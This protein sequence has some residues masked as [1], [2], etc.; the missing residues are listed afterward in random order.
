MVYVLSYWTAC[1]FL[2]IPC[3]IS[4]HMLSLSIVQLVNSHTS[5][6]TQLMYLILQEIFSGH[7]F[8]TVQRDESPSSVLLMYLKHA[9]L[10]I[11]T[12]LHFI[13]FSTFAFSTT[14]SSFVVVCL[15]VWDFWFLGGFF[16]AAPIAYGRFQA[17]DQI[18]AAAAIYPTAAVMLDPQ[19][20]APQWELLPWVL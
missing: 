13:L 19:P 8:S 15:F 3:F 18:W 2:K 14:V 11:I 10:W 17:R 5:F 7:P 4:L 16:L 6:R 1:N 20:T 12:I 9:T